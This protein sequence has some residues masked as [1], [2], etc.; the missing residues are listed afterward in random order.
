MNIVVD[1]H[2]KSQLAM[3][4]Q[5]SL[6]IYGL[7]VDILGEKKHYFSDYP[8]FSQ[9]AKNNKTLGVNSNGVFGVKNS[10]FTTKV[11][12][13]GNTAWCVVEGSNTGIPTLSIL[14]Y[15]VT[16]LALLRNEIGCCLE[17]SKSYIQTDTYPTPNQTNEVIQVLLIPLNTT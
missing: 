11:V 3:H 4:L 10:N 16:W 2:K 7:K 14:S 8:I 15:L 1:Y 9:K 12:K 17:S 5:L 6:Q 13:V